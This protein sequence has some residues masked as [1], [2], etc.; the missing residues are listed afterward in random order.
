MTVKRATKTSEMDI[1]EFRDYCLS[2]PN[3]E[4]CTPFDETT[5]VFKVHGK[6]FAYGDMVDFVAVSLKCD[7]DRAVELREQYEAVQ[8][9]YHMNKRHWNTVSTQTDLP[10]ALLR[11]WILDSYRLVVASLPRKLRD[12]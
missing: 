7:P 5:L 12:R 9:G 4:E 11:E 6:I 2:L 1:L 8:P 3:T 10:D